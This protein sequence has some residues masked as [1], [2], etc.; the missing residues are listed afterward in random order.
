MQLSFLF[1]SLVTVAIIAEAALS[2]RANPNDTSN[3]IYKNPNASVEARVADLLG[4]MTIQDK[5]AQLIQGDLTSWINQTNDAFNETGLVWSMENRAG[6]FYVGY[7]IA[8]QWISEGIKVAQDYL[9]KNTTLGIP[10]LV[11]SEG[12]HGFLACEF[13]ETICLIGYPGD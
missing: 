11:Q 3:A 5:T 13:S 7:P 1:V 4:R 8:Q 9:I 6:F 2:G 12:I 10:A